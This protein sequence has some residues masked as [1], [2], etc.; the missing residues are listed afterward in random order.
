[1]RVAERLISFGRKFGES[2]GMSSSNRGDNSILERDQVAR[3]I[4]EASVAVKWFIEETDTSPAVGL[5]DLYVNGILELKAPLLMRSSRSQVHGR[6][7]IIWGQVT[8]RQE[9]LRCVLKW[10]EL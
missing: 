6:K 2:T 5:K 9:T 10:T 4:T 7:Q 3:H 1:M 8:F